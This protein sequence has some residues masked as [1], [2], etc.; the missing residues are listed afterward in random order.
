MGSS[1]LLGKPL[2]GGQMDEA[3]RRGGCRSPM[4]HH[5]SWVLSGKE[6][7]R[8]TPC[9]NHTARA[10]PPAPEPSTP[11]PQIA[12]FNFH[13]HSPFFTSFIV[14][15]HY[16]TLTFPRA[17]QHLASPSHPS[18][19]AP[20]PPLCPSLPIPQGSSHCS[21]ACPMHIKCCFYPA[22]CWEGTSACK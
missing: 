3:A 12:Q 19:A 8:S 22:C 13:L 9:A 2:R 11:S 1:E 15:Y 18:F 7:P 4:L 14:S 21:P 20:V 5:P 16:Q 6:Q 10:H 17:E